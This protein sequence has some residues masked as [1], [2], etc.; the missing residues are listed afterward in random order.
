V[1]FAPSRAPQIVLSVLLSNGPVWHRKAKAVGR[2][3][4]RAYF[5][6]RGYRGVTAPSPE[7]TSPGDR[8]PE[9]L[10]FD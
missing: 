5:A 3:V 9:L 6:A 2:D 1:G 7:D 10:A 8:E 4:L